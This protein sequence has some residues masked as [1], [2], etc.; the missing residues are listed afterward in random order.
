MRRSAVRRALRSV[1]QRG[2]LASARI[3]RADVY[4]ISIV[5][6]AAHLRATRHSEAIEKVREPARRLEVDG[7]FTFSHTHL[8]PSRAS[9]NANGHARRVIRQGGPCCSE[10]I[11]FRTSR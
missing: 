2:V 5:P 4:T 6:G 7:W 3:A 10:A 8:R 11:Q 9:V 1:P